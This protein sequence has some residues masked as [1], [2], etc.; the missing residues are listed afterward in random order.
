MRAHSIVAHVSIVF[1]VTLL[2][3]NSSARFC[4]VAGS[5]VPVL[6]K[7]SVNVYVVCL[8]DVDASGVSNI[9]RV[10]EGALLASEVDRVRYLTG[11]L[12]PVGMTF[13][14]VMG[15]IPIN[16]SVTV[17]TDWTAY[18][19]LVEY[20]SNVI[21]VNA[22]GGILPVPS[23]CDEEE[24]VDK[25]AEAMLYRNVTWVHTGGYPFY[26][27][28]YQKNGEM[29]WGEEG[30]KRFMRQIGKENVTCWA[31]SDIA[32]EYCGIT[33]TAWY[34]IATTT[35]L[36]FPLSIKIGNPIERSSIEDVH[37]YSIYSYCYNEQEYD[38]GVTIAFTKPITRQSFGFYVHLGGG[39][40]FKNGP[41]PTDRDF[42]AGYVGGAVAIWSH[43]MKA[44]SLTAISEAQRAIIEA[45]L[46]KRIKGLDKA[47]TLLQEA[48]DAY[49]SNNYD[50]SNGT[51]RL[52]QEAK[53]TAEEGSEL[54]ILEA[55]SL[56]FL[57]IS[58][59]SIL[60]IAA[61]IVKWKNG[62]SKSSKQVE[63][64]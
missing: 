20:A 14:E 51:V 6:E 18:K 42:D 61:V 13:L 63:G 11:E 36:E 7:Q 19:V 59:T 57:T 39:Q 38:S 46:E 31:P 50:G 25:I 5:E 30:F 17:V 43:V 2:L 28:F 55:Y 27:V 40:T 60:I 49:I 21:I 41:T 29:A 48:D 62:K 9:S 1:L 12:E 26:R 10:F 37:V 56:H 35:W 45:E 23:D 44:T 58:A 8:D 3:M 64:K 15:E 32:D 47:K 34:G 53:K 16:V 33:P 4:F 54:N 22:H 24:W 52:A